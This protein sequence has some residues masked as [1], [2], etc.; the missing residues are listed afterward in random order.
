MYV[1]MQVSDVDVAKVS[2]GQ[3]VRVRFD[4]F[5]DQEPLVGTVGKV[6]LYG[7]V[8][9]GMTIYR[10]PVAFEPGQMRPRIGMS[11]NIAVPLATKEDV[12]TVPLMAIQYDRKGPYVLVVTGEETEPRHVELGIGDGIHVEVISGLENGDMI[13]VPMHGPMGPGGYVRY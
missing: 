8:Q 4:A 10:V 5:H 6:P 11:A 2:E 3:Q 7:T 13:R 9:Q 1:E 12:L